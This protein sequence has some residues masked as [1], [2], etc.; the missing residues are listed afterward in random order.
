MIVSH[1]R[2]RHLDYRISD[3]GHVALFRH[4]FERALACFRSGCTIESI[5]HTA[6]S[7]TIHDRGVIAACDMLLGW[8]DCAE[9]EARLSAGMTRDEATRFV[10]EYREDN[11]DIPA[12]PL[13][14]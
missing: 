12:N 2:Y 5:T 10:A 14:Y 4:G 11:E 8:V 13:V 1:P 6:T 7:G 3:T 9:R